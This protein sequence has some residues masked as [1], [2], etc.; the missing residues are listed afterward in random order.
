MYLVKKSI[1]FFFLNIQTCL[2]D[3]EIVERI[4]YIYIENGLEPYL[5]LKVNSSGTVSNHLH[6]SS[7]ALASMQNLLATHDVRLCFKKSVLLCLK[8]DLNVLKIRLGL[9]YLFRQI[10]EV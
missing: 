3:N 5:G 10:N 2:A 1:P 8:T 7:Y 6:P 4:S 9:N